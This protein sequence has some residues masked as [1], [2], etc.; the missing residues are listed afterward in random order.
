MLLKQKN[1]SKYHRVYLLI[2]PK[3]LKIK[4][5]S[6][7]QLQQNNIWKLGAVFTELL[8]YLIHGFNGV[9]SFRSFIT[10]TLTAARGNILPIS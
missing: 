6:Y 10:T 1:T 4:P 8:T 7:D 3:A 9:P 5:P 2:L